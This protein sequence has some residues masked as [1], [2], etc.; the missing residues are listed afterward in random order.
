MWLLGRSAV[1]L[2][3]HP[4]RATR[5]ATEL[6]RSVPGLALAARPLAE[7]ITSGHRPALMSGAGLRAPVTPFNG[8][9]SA[10]RRWATA[11]LPLAEVK[12]VRRGTQLTVN[13]VVMALC[14]GTLRR[15]LAGHDQLPAAPLVAAVPVSVRRKD[16]A[17]TLRQ[18]DLADAGRPAD[19]ARRPGRA[20]RRDAP[21]AAGG[22][23]PA[24]RHTG[25]AA[26]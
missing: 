11:D 21:G 5:L 22:Q 26:R 12:E 3:T 18:P 6:A 9:I 7:R 10:H 19:P 16:Q 25:R 23:G 20:A 17:G 14:A 4:L 2:A 24:R 13:D 15:Y 8:L 1:T